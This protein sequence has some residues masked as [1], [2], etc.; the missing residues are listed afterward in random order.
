[1]LINERFKSPNKEFERVF[2]LFRK[3][4]YFNEKSQVKKKQ[5]EFVR[6]LKKGDPMATKVFKQN[7]KDMKSSLS[8]IEDMVMD[9][10]KKNHFEN[11]KVFSTAVNDI[12]MKDSKSAPKS[13]D[14]IKRKIHNNSQKYSLAIYS[15]IRKQKFNNY[16]DVHKDVDELISKN[17]GFAS[18]AQRKAAFASGY[19]AKGKKGKKKNESVNEDSMSWEKNFKGY[20]EKELKVIS[21]FIMMNPKGIDG[22]IK[23]SKNKDFKP[24]IKKM[25]Q[26]GLHEGK[27]R[28]Y[29]QD[30]VG[31]AKYTI[32]YHDGKKKHKDGSDFFDIQTFRN[33]K[34]LAKFVNT[35]HKGGYVY[36]FNESV[37]E[38]KVDSILK[39]IKS[40]YDKSKNKKLDI[41][42]LK[43]QLKTYKKLGASDKKDQIKAG[44]MFLKS[45]GESVN[46][47]RLNVRDLPS[48]VLE[49]PGDFEDWYDAGMEI[50]G[51]KK[52][53]PMSKSDERK[54]FNLIEMWIESRDDRRYG[55]GSREDTN[56][57][58]KSIEKFLKQKGKVVK[59]SVNEAKYYN[60]ADALTAYF[61][62][63][64]D[65]KELDKIARNQFKSG[66]ATK[67]ELSNFLSNKFTQ[68]VM[69]DT[70][71]IPAGTLVKRVRG[72]MKF[73]E[74]KDGGVPQGY[75]PMVESKTKESKVVQMIYKYEKN[76][77]K[78]YDK[79][80]EHERRIGPR[81]Y[82]KFIINAL[83]GFGINPRE[84]KRVPDAEEKLYQT[85]SKK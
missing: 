23:M 29:Q 41:K 48:Y 3:K 43:D 72:L 75:N 76:E 35:L 81:E 15:A 26:K 73:A 42:K 84:F 25:A 36:G 69:S 78:F 7:K 46:E 24:L 49:D 4:D 80:A 56:D 66:I 5:E 38:G 8:F 45:I 31:S 14:S 12:E 61:K 33:K 65:A 85:V 44:Q 82:G 83:R 17:E 70:Y 18:D 30:R 77:K 2:N 34:D 21:K 50:R 22:V 32:S 74:G 53:A 20:N 11:F 51:K 39:R 10:N 27:K 71:G 57:I 6:F 68:S 62:G 58:I 55:S 19:K 47:A 28:Y 63:K 13:A 54:L 16:K 1:M 60:K 67:K 59:E 64:I 79:M 9:Y 37:N 40:A 52:L